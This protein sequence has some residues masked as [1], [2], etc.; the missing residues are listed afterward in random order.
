MTE[1]ALEVAL[2]TSILIF[3]FNKNY[4]IFYLLECCFDISMHQQ[5]NILLSRINVAKYCDVKF[6]FKVTRTDLV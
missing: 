1:N 2:F 5:L 3:V 6:H 4:L